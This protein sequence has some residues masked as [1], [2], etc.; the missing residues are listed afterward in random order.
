MSARL[1]EWLARYERAVQFV[2]HR[3][4]PHWGG[5]G[6]ED[7]VAAG[8]RGI[9]NAERSYRPDVGRTEDSW[10]FLRIQAEMLELLRRWFGRSPNGRRTIT[11][12]VAPLAEAAG[13][14]VDPTPQVDAR[15]DCERLLSRLAPA[16]RAEIEARFFHGQ[17]MGEIGL[18]RGVTESA[19]HHSLK[20]SLRF[21]RE[22]A[23]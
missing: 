18:R 17:T 21:L 13:L 20:K 4:T 14:T 23:A 19:V 12:N 10:A 7:L 2:A 1:H 5:L 8:R 22:V 16:A 15:L 6:H 9:V 11:M 3:H